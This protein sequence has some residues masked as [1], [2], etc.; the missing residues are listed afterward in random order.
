MSL[1][2]AKL[3]MNSTKLDIVQ[4]APTNARHVWRLACVRSAVLRM[5]SIPKLNRVL[6]AKTLTAE[7]VLLLIIPSAPSANLD[8]SLSMAH[9]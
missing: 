2:S 4:N 7:F 9:A 6:S 1:Y 5:V 3:D 8:L